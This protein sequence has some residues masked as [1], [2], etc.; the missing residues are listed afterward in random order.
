MEIVWIELL[1]PKAKKILADLAK[2]NLIRTSSSNSGDFLTTVRELRK[3]NAGKISFDEI[4]K[5]VEL[6]RKKR[7]A[8]KKA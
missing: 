8:R 1:N 4:T 3:K 5:E 2:Q 7:Y 6:V